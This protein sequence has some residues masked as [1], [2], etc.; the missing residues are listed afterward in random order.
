MFD[1]LSLV[2]PGIVWWT[3]ALAIAHYKSY[4]NAFI[5]PPLLGALCGGMQIGRVAFSRAVSET[6]LARV[7]FAVMVCL[8]FAFGLLYPEV[9]VKPFG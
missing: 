3:I 5:E 4:G 7:I 9:P 2:I 1:Y 8:S 6:I